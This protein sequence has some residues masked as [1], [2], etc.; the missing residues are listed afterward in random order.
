[1]S[2]RTLLGLGGDGA[3][4]SISR[5]AFGSTLVASAL[6]WL[7]ADYLGWPFGFSAFATLAV[8]VTGLLVAAG[9]SSAR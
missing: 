4:V 8:L 1:M 5:L 7:V 9:P 3:Q 6:T 2:W